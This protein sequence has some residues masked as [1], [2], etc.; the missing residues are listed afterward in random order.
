MLSGRRKFRGPAREG[1]IHQLPLCGKHQNL[2]FKIRKSCKELRIFLIKLPHPHIQVRAAALKLFSESGQ[3]FF[4][5]FLLRGFAFVQLAHQIPLE[6]FIL[7][8]VFPHGCR[9]FPAAFQK[10]FRPFCVSLQDQQICLVQIHRKALTIL[11][12]DSFQLLF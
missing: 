10:F 5:C 8:P 11:T 2:Q 4:L 3:T 6:L 1:F 7:R 9:L 12:A